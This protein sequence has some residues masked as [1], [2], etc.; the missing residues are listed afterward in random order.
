MAKRKSQ[1]PPKPDCGS[2]EI[3]KMIEAINKGE[4]VNPCPGSPERD[5]WWKNLWKDMDDAVAYAKENGY[6]TKIV[7]SYVE[8]DEYEEA[9]KSEMF[10]EALPDGWMDNLLEE[11]RQKGKDAGKA[12]K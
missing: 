8:P 4:K 9:L 3:N 7:F 5:R 11:Q 6:P 1:L 12:K 2:I 10:D